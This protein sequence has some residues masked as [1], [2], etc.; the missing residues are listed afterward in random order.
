MPTALARYADDERAAGRPVA[1]PHVFHCTHRT[2][3]VGMIDVA[4]VLAADRAV[5]QEAAP[6]PVSVLVGT[7]SHC[8]GAVRKITIGA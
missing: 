2:H 4:D 3:G 5:A 6:G 8:H 1:G 7:A